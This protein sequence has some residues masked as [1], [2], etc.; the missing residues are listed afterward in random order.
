MPGVL[1]AAVCLWIGGWTG[2]VWGFVISTVIL[3]HC[4]FFINSLSHLIG[5]RRYATTDESRNNLVLALITLGEGWHNNHHHYMSSAN[6]GFFWWEI[7]IS[8]YVIRLLSFV[9]LTWDVRRPGKKALSFR[10][11]DQQPAPP[12]PV[13]V[14]QEMVSGS[15]S[16]DTPKGLNTSAGG[17]QRTPGD[18]V[19]GPIYPAGVAWLYNP[20]GVGCRIT[21]PFFGGARVRDPRLGYPTPSG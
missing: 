18:D 1:L 15:A 17:R 4:T 14:G 5:R 9:G 6:Q 20:C 2:F 12:D 21:P 7:D 10:R 11:I 13:G 16:S 3:Y 8:Y 19:K